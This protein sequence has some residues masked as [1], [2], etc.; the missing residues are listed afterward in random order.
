VL[1]RANRCLSWELFK[2]ALRSDYEDIQG[3]TTPEGIH[4][5]AMAGSVDIVQRGYTDIHPRG[6]VLWFNPSIPVELD[7][8]YL[9]LRYRNQSL[10]VKITTWELYVRAGEA[11]TAPVKIGYQDE[12]H[13]LDAGESVTIKLKESAVCI[14]EGQEETA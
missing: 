6:D 14:L 9:R 4:V 3:G 13:E 1:A 10:S 11:T 2:Q 12:V 5:G 7:R 8:L